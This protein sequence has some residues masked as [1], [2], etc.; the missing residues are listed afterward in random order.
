MKTEPAKPEP[1][2]IDRLLVAYELAKTKV[3]EANEALGAI[4]VSVREVLKED[5]QRRAE[6]DSVRTGLARLQ[7]IKV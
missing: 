7:S 4:A 5:R 2:A 6:I 1:T 3:R